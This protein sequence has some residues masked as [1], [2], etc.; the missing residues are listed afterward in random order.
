MLLRTQY[1]SNMIG[2]IKKGC[3]TMSPCN[4]TQSSSSSLEYRIGIQSVEVEILYSII[5]YK[6]NSPRILFSGIMY[7]V[8]YSAKRH[9]ETITKL[10]NVTLEC[11][12]NNFGVPQGIVLGPIF[13]LMWGCLLC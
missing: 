10:K 3:S 5:F 8:V 2:N 13:F 11:V 4:G 7:G 6:R 9:S 1:L 12:P